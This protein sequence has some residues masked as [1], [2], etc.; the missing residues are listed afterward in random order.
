M[1]FYQ[2]YNNIIYQIINTKFNSSFILTVRDDFL[3]KY[4]IN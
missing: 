2:L 3:R 4:Y 1:I